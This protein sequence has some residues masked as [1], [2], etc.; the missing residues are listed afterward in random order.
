MSFMKFKLLV[1]SV[2][3]FF[4]GSA[5][6]STHDVSADTS[7]LSGQSGYPYPQYDPLNRV[8]S[9]A[10]VM[11]FTTNGV[12][13]SR[14]AATSVAPVPEPRTLALCGLGLF[15]CVVIVKRRQNQV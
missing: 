13:G 4:A 14:D 15:A 1:V 7:S 8:S 9:A 3:M 12:P 5:F 6:A 2:V 10:E 11:N